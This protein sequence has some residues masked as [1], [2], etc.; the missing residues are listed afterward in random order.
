MTDINTV[1]ASLRRPSL[2]IRAARF[3][4]ADY[5]RTRDLK[6]VIGVSQNTAPTKVID[7]L[8]EK[9]AQFEETRKA[10]DAGY[11]VARHIEVLIALMAEARLLPRGPQSV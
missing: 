9:E 2:L 10:G 3:G 4:L 7:G 8:I 1:L 5:N 6:R 11:S